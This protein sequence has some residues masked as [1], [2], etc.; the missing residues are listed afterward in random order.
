MSDAA[1]PD[2]SMTD[3]QE[4][5]SVVPESADKP[6]DGAPWW[7]RWLVAALVLGGLGA[8][9]YV[10]GDIPKTE[11][12]YGFWSVLPPLIAIVL[13]F[14]LQEVVSALF[15]GI[16]AGGIIAGQVNI[17]DAFLLPA[18]GTED[19]ALILLVYLWALGG[20]IGLWTR[21]GGALRFAKWA[22][23]RMVRGPRTAKF[24]TWIMGLVFHQGGT[25]STVL[26]GA[27]TRPIGDQHDV[28]T[29]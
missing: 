14:W 8:A 25:I 29:T 16:A 20:L 4:T 23:E 12:H 13:A 17:I 2:A 21:T 24:F 9:V 15:I 10:A 18:I 11:G 3:V 6:G 26:T 22:G 27:T 19:F 28:S 7:R 5:G 1:E